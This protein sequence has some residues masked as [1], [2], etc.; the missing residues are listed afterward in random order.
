MALGNQI[1]QGFWN[2]SGA[3]LVQGAVVRATSGSFQTQVTPAQA[4]SAGH[5]TGLVG[6][7]NTATGIGGFCNV[8]TSGDAMC[9]FE[10]GLTLV[11]GQQVYLSATVAGRATNVAPGTAIIIGIIKNTARYTATGLVNITVSGVGGGSGGTGA[12]GFQG[13]AGAQGAQGATGTG[14][15]GSQGSQGAQGSAGAQGSQGSQGSQGA[16]GA[17]GAAGAGGSQGSQGSAG[18]QGAQGTAGNQGPD[19]AAITP[20]LVLVPT[21]AILPGSNPA[22]LVQIDGTNFSYYVLGFTAGALDRA[23]FPF[24]LHGYS[25][26]N[27][28]FDIYWYALTDASAGHVNTFGIAMAKD[29]PSV[30]TTA[31][32]ALATGT[33]DTQ[34]SGNTTANAKAMYL[35]TVT[36]SHTQSAVAGDAV[37]ARVRVLTTG[38]TVTG[39]TYVERIVV[40]YS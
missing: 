28:L 7:T 31:V 9:L 5:S 26:G 18:S 35:T 25:G 4:D 1:L 23:D 33:E 3:A 21:A 2:A 11:A 39:E 40:R 22:T 29:T 10:S 36:V 27:I 32:D 37:W 17:Q 19:G 16:Q 12:Q 30:T 34:A 13:A 20:A 38:S 14:N 6:V 8:V 24:D 15:Q